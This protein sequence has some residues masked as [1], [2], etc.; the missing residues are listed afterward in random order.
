M[1]DAS[2][3]LH[4]TIRE[5]GDWRGETLGEGRRSIL[6]VDLDIVEEWTW[7]KPTSPGVPVWSHHG[8]ICSGETYENVHIS[9]GTRSKRSWPTTSGK[10]TAPTGHRVWLGERHVEAA[11]RWHPDGPTRLGE[12]AG[13]ATIEKAA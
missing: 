9:G 1:T 2:E 5:L 12:I 10:R 6:A 3:L 4:Q 11:S 8:A 7:V 13:A